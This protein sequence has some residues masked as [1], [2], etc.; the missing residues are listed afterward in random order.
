QRDRCAHG[1]HPPKARWRV[2][3]QVDPYRARGRLHP[4]R[5]GDGMKRFR[6]TI[7]LRLTLWY[8]AALLAVLMVYAGVVFAFLEHNLWQQ[9]DR[10]LHE[11]VEDMDA[12]IHASSSPAALS[13]LYNEDSDDAEQSWLEVWS[14]DGR[15]LLQS[16]RAARQPLTTIGPPRGEALRSM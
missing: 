16:V 9:L 14:L 2:A 6:L 7:R 10:R 11:E 5:G 1:A 8:A 12:L 3:D 13:D 15:R 4:A